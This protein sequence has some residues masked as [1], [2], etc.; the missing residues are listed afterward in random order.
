M[1]KKI[2]ELTEKSVLS[3]TETLLIED[4]DG[5]NKS[6]LVSSLQ[7]YIQEI[8]SN[9]VEYNILTDAASGTRINQ[10]I[11]ANR[12]SVIKITAINIAVATD[13]IDVFLPDPATL[14]IGD[15]FKEVNV[16]VIARNLSGTLANFRARIR[17]TSDPTSNAAYVIPTSSNTYTANNALVFTCKFVYVRD[18]FGTGQ[19]HWARVM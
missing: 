16:I 2:S 1:S 4:V 6:V 3:G 5:K 11:A 19:H 13:G 8:T 14:T 17:Y 9:Q 18:F 12:T 15:A 10:N 7:D